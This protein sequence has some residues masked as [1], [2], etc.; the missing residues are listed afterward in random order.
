MDNTEIAYLKSEDEFNRA[1]RKAL[2]EEVIA[3]L[4]GSNLD[5]LSFEEVVQKLRLRNT[6]NRGLQDVPLK[7]IAGSCGRYT[8]FTRTFTPRRAGRD[9]ERWRQIYTL[10]VTGKGFPPIEVYK[11][12]QVYFV[13]DGNHRVSVARELKWET[14]QAYVTELPTVFTLTPDAKPDDLLIKEEC[15]IFLEK[16]R[17]HELRPEAD[18]TFTIPGR[19]NRLLRQ[20]SVYRYYLSKRRT[21][22]PGRDETVVDWYDNFYAPMIARIKKSGVMKL[23]PGRTPDDLLAWIV[24]H[25]K[26]LRISEQVDKVG[27]V[28]DVQ[29]FLAFIDKL[30]PLDVAKVEMGKKIKNVLKR[31]DDDSTPPGGTIE[32]YV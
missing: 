27:Y 12:D 15:A 23:F 2:I 13:R 6:V 8:D 31:N 9:K 21:D 7:Q 5:L 25:Q 29:D 19:Y 1:R 3:G 24:E 16:T 28:H 10:A 14:I 32:R 11:I 4:S 30:S 17:L 20:I 22:I 18:I 26:D